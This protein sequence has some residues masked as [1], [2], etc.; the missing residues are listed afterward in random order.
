MFTWRWTGEIARHVTTC[1]QSSVTKRAVFWPLMD[2][3]GAVVLQVQV[4]E[5]AVQCATTPCRAVLCR[6]RL[7]SVSFPPQSVMYRYCASAIKVAFHDADI[8]TDTDILARMSVS[9]SA[10]WNAAF[11]ARSSC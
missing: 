11:T 10:S 5:A 8:D 7:P 6:A 1:S 3:E 4:Q 9:V 2:L